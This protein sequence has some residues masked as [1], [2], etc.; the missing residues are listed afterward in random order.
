MGAR[1]GRDRT[2]GA[3]E[4]AL[5]RD[6]PVDWFLLVGDRRLVGAGLL[7]LVAL[8]VGWTVASGLAPLTE[9]TPLLYLL[10]SLLSGNVTLITIVV[11]ISQFVLARH[12]ESP[13]EART[14]LREAVGYRQEVSEV[15]GERVVPVTPAG[16]LR[17]LLASIDRDVDSLRERE[18]A[19]AEG[20]LRADVEALVG[21]LAEHAAAV[22]ALVERTDGS[23]DRALFS[24]LEMNYSRFFYGV[25]R[26]RAE[27]G[28]ALPE[29]VDA[30]LRRLERDV[31]QIDVARRYFKTVLIQTELASL[32]RLL[33]LIGLPVLV[34]T[35]VL[36]LAFT[37]TAGPAVSAPALSVAI[38][39]VVTAGFAPI[40]LLT[41]SIL[42][43]AT[44]VHRTAAMYPFTTRFDR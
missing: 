39:L 37:A 33:L 15:T 10:F 43:L 1:R 11:S 36:M 2:W 12:L 40:A 27:Y 20:D 6:R 32:S 22:S 41:A 7:A 31:E 23:V 30:D 21:E 16:F 5:F 4:L 17:T 24:T 29:T 3:T 26:L 35:V 19:D 38:P 18:W 9:R 42:R 34:A 25:Y 14:A 44:V 28:E 13:G 8:A